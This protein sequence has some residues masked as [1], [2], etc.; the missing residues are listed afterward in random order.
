MVGRICR[1]PIIISK[2]GF[3]ALVE[4]VNERGWRKKFH[5]LHKNA[6]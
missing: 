1:I 5:H 4:A 6:I 2:T 3:Y